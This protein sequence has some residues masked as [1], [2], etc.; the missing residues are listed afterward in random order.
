[1]GQI[2]GSTTEGD[3]NTSEWLPILLKTSL[4]MEHIPEITGVRALQLL[5]R[6]RADVLLSACVMATYRH[7]R[8]HYR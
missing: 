3:W 4:A 6:L 1:M 2:C 5:T 7:Y 8:R